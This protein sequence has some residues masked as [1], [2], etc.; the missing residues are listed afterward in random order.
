MSCSFSDIIGGVC[1]ADERARNR[2]SSTIPL[3]LCDK[4]ISSH[5]Q[6]LQFSGVETEV[7]LILARC[8]IF[9]RPV[10]LSEMT[11]CPCHRSKLGIG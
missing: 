9:E 6:S 8:G 7:D 2:S 4:D 10:R 3:S 1:G 11:I 5:K